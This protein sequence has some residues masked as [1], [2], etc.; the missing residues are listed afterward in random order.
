MAEDN[1]KDFTINWIL[2]GFLLTCLLSF[3]VTFMFANNEGGLGDDADAIYGD[4]VSDFSSQL[5]SS[6]D[7]SDA[8]L[9]ITANTNPEASDLGSRDSVSTSYKA[10]GSGTGYWETSKTLISW[11][12][13]GT[14][15]KMLI[16]VFAGIIGMLSYFYIA[17]HIRTGD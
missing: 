4:S 6:S 16:S 7:E 11:I 13:T 15:G 8:I 12:F 1:L 14:T 9:N 17:K 3:A 5:L 10:K 2:T